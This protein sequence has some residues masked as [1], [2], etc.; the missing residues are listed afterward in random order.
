MTLAGCNMI[1]QM[2]PSTKIAQDT[3]LRQQQLQARTMRFADEYVGRVVEEATRF[4]ADLEDPKF[5]YVI[6]GWTLSQAN[7][8]YSSAAGET[9]TVNALDL[10]TLAVLSRMV[11]EDTLLPAFPEQGRA[12]LETHRQLE[13]QAWTMCDE[14]MTPEQ[15]VQFRSVLAEWREQNPKVSSVAFI[16]FLDFAKQVG[17]PRVDEAKQAGGLF[18]MLGVDPLAGLDPAIQQL[19]Q[20]RQLAERTIYYL[21]RMP[22]ILNLQGER[23]GAGFFAREEIQ[24]LVTNVGQVSGAAERVS[25]V[26]AMLPEQ[27]SAERE[28]FIRQ[29]SLEMLAQQQAL[30][31]LL[32]DMR[33]TLEAGSTA[34]ESLNA[35]VRSVDALMA[36]FPAKQPGAGAPAGKP[37]DIADYGKAAAEFARTAAELR[38][39]VEALDAQVPAVQASLDGAV[40]HGQ[41]LI[42][43]LFLR[44]AALIV[45]LVGTLL[46]AAFVYRRVIARA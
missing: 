35:M 13:R 24:S 9:P 2:L 29:L 11:I 4:R 44:I 41:S 43:Y 36:R 18:A 3:K 37:F 40:S 8:A 14:F 21:Q 34:A 15:I 39:L 23:I 16:H 5:R 46:G 22:Y 20:T 25:L 19:E 10:V 27:I 33:G 1:R 42:D 28:A 7:S 12:L 6:S 45:L 38:S 26:A 32:A 17:R 30:R 31:P